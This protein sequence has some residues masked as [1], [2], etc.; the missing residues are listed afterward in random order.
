MEPG[1]SVCLW[2]N[3][4]ECG[5]GMNEVN[6]AGVMAGIDVICYGV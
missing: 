6:V 1:D 4:V 2:R 3:L 5:Y